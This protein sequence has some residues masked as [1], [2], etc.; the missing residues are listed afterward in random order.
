MQIWEARYFDQLSGHP[1]GVHVL[2]ILVPPVATGGNKHFTP[3]GN[4]MGL[5]AWGININFSTPI[6]AGSR[7]TQWCCKTSRT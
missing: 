1:C 7:G 3:R 6:S 2:E 5:L 4:D